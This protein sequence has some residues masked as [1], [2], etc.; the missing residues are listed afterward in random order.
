MKQG[1]TNADIARRFV[2]SPRTVQ[3][4][5]T[6]ILAKLGTGRRTELATQAVSR[7][8]PQPTG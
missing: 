5:L 7:G 6:H 2:I 1:L 4:H 8:F 3:S